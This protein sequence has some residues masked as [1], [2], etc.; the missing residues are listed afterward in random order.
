MLYPAIPRV[1]EY[2]RTSDV[3]GEPI[4]ITWHIRPTNWVELGDLITI[5]FPVPVHMTEET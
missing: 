1:I 3:N 5:N 2:E 4:N